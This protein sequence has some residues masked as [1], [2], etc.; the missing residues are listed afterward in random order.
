[1]GRS[2]TLYQVQQYDTE[3]DNAA[4]RIQEIETILSDNL[5]LEEALQRRQACELVLTDK[6]KVL[7]SAEVIVN[8]H[9]LK[10]DQN[11]KKLY[12]G[13]I[14]NPKDLEDL[15]LEA[16]SLNKYLRVLEERQLEAMLEMEESQREFNEASSNVEVI[17]SRMESEHADLIIEKEKLEKLIS[18]K[19]SQKESF[20]ST[21]EI[22]DLATYQSIRNS[23]GGIGV[24]LMVSNSCSSCGANIPSA[25]AQE[26]RSPVKLAF[27]PTCKRILHSG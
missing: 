10:I 22:S 6:K 4:K 9:S 15:Q 8:D 14:T 2:K 1:M 24:T 12:S 3:I 19:T 13:S 17:K 5:A 20:L 18:A 26:A 23:S 25:I 27:C 16:E 11:Q 7:A 21:N